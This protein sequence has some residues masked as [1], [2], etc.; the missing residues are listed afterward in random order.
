M[1]AQ[2][3]V[4]LMGGYDTTAVTA[5]LASILLAR[6]PQY[7][8]RLRHEM[9]ELVKE[10]GSV[11][12]QGVMEAKFLDACLNGA[13]TYKTWYPATRLHIQHSVIE[14]AQINQYSP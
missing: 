1:A 4:F 5:T 3:V 2:S 9:Q 6:H 10:H 14:I 12:Y 7:Q 8:Q 13:S 11:T